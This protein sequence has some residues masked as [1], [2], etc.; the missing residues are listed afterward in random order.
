MAWLYSLAVECGDEAAVR[1]CAEHFASEDAMPIDV[2]VVQSSDDG[3][4]WT[5]IVPTNE[6]T[7]GVHSDEIARSLTA[8]GEAVLDRLRSAPL[9]RFAVIGVEAQ[10]AIAL[11]DFDPALGAEPTLAER[12]DG[13]VVSDALHERLGTPASFEPFAPGYRWIPY[14]GERYREAD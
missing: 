3:A 11:A 4:W 14:R 1:S 9:F 7:S 8:A 13:L 10:E 5:L 12:F 2:S 6:S